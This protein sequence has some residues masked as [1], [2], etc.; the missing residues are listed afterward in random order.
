MQ[1]IGFIGLGNM[2][3]PMASNLCRKGFELL[4]YDIN[5]QAVAALCD[6]GARIASS[7]A[8]I[9]KTCDILITMLPNSPSPPANSKLVT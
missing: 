5:P 6:L 3:R 8:E 1:T 4:V 9:A 2:G 7:V